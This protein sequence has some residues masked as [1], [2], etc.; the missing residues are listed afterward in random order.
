MGFDFVY[1][2]AGVISIAGM[3]LYYV[4]L[5][6]YGRFTRHQMDR[7]AEAKTLVEERR[8]HFFQEALTRA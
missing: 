8:Q 4:L 1:L 5:G 6:R 2:A 3:A 7:T